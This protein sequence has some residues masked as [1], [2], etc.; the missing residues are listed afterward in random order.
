M[1]SLFFDD[2]S[3]EK[4]LKQA[5]AGSTLQSFLETYASYLLDN[6]IVEDKESCFA[7][8]GRLVSDSMD[9]GECS[10]SMMEHMK[11]FVQAYSIKTEGKRKREMFDALMHDV[12][13]R[14]ASNP[15]KLLSPAMVEKLA[16]YKQLCDDCRHLEQELAVEMR[17]V[18]SETIGSYVGGHK[19]VINLDFG[20]M[21]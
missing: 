5:V 20:S 4:Q 13:Y 10:V 8:I 14:L 3:K 6:R 18:I 7:Q 12:C 19:S 21:F 16:K 2:G 9:R 15:G 17:P 1:G 11:K